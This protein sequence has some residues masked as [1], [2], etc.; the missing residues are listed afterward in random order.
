MHSVSGVRSCDCED[1][2]IIFS[3]RLDKIISQAQGETKIWCYP[4]LSLWQAE[5]KSL[6]AS[7]TTRG[8]EVQT[9]H[10]GKW[11][12]RQ[13]EHRPKESLAFPIKCQKCG[14]VALVLFCSVEITNAL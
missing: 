12:P 5:F 4:I 10:L 9:W 8:A 1:A 6:P 2:Q 13:V 7:L 14:M 3:S 11:H